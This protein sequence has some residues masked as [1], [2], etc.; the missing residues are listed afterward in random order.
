LIGGASILINYG[1]REM[2][3][4]M[5]AIISS[6]SAIK[7]AIN[8]VGDKFNLPD[9]WLNTDFVNTKSYTP[10][11]VEYSVHYRCYANILN[12]RTVASE[13][14]IAMKLMSG[15]KFKNDL[16]DVIGILCEHK[17]QNNPISQEQIEKAVCDL[18]GSWDIIAEDSRMFIHS[19]TESEQYDTLYD[20][21]RSEELSNRDV[22]LDIEK[23]YPGVTNEN[24]IDEVLAKAKE[25][26]EKDNS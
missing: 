7:E 20:Q 25:R 16:S 6:S 13:Y 15:R 3:Y 9:G 11:L 4:D 23:L 24:N 8:R 1:F 17:A 22:L 10:K 12:V 18:Y 19:V 26:K 21:Y 14:L 5:D 2:T